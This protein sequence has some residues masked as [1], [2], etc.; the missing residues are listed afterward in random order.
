RH[1]S[2][3][4]PY[5]PMQYM[6]HSNVCILRRRLLT[7][8]LLNKNPTLTFPLIQFSQEECATES[9]IQRFPAVSRNSLPRGEI[10]LR[11]GVGSLLS[12]G[13]HSPSARLFVQ[14]PKRH[15]LSFHLFG[16]P[17]LLRMPAK[18]SL[19]FAHSKPYG[20]GE[21][22]RLRRRQLG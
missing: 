19:G 20:F 2:V 9:P 5:A 6:P 22:L 17:R 7:H 14:T 16:G 8:K 1:L 21:P 13:V 11:Q 10:W 12:G 18:E 4:N 15:P 3:G